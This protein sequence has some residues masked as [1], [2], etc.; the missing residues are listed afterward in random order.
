M[1]IEM[2]IED[3]LKREIEYYEQKRYKRAAK[4]YEKPIK[5]EPIS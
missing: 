3:I 2:T 5:K 1:L 4:E